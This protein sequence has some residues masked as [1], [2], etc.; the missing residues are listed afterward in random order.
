LVST[1]TGHVEY[2][3][4]KIGLGSK[5][6]GYLPQREN[7]DWDFPITVRSSVEMGR[8]AELGWFKPFGNKDKTMVDQALD[9]MNLMGLQDR[10][11]NALSGGQQ[12][13]AF[14]AR[15]LAQEAHVLLLDEP[16]TGLDFTAQEKLGALLKK[17]AVEG[18]LIITSLH[19]LQNVSNFFDKAMLIN[20]ELI[21]CGA[22]GDVL[23]RQNI[24]RAYNTPVF[25]GAL[26]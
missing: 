9:A 22:T 8:Y 18:H 11:L 2:H 6:I 12:Q 24:E 21:A 4:K 17:L 7:V 5:E 14:L 26:S 19:D 23:T 3:G 1:E 20:G 10:Q 16:F 15:L 13:R 25:T